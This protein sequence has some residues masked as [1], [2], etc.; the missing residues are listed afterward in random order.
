MFHCIFIDCFSR[1]SWSIFVKDRSLLSFQ[2]YSAICFFA[3]LFVCNYLA[4]NTSVIHSIQ[5]NKKESKSIFGF[6]SSLKLV[7]AL[8][9]HQHSCW[10]DNYRWEQLWP[11]R[12]I[13]S[14]LQFS[15]ARMSTAKGK[16][17]S[18]VFFF[19]SEEITECNRSIERR[20][21]KRI[22]SIRY[23]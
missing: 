17:R 6:S 3:F 9:H 1:R 13:F 16:I 23:K 5:L 12:I 14:F 18:C 20:S 21:T 8:A 19:L 4:L 15:F 11:W 2:Q 7:F 10:S 22:S